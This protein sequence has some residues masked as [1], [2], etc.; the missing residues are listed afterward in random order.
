MLMNKN[1]KPLKIN[2]WFY[3]FLIQLFIIFNVNSFNEIL[4]VAVQI[5]IL[6]NSSSER[7]N[8]YPLHIELPLG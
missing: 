8:S 7:F 3:I 4:S 5:A 2:E 1:K 6:N